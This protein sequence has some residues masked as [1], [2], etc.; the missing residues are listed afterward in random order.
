MAN[1]YAPE[2]EVSSNRI[3]AAG[4]SR[5]WRSCYDEFGDEI[6]PLSDWWSN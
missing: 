6:P 3:D 4:L 5:F 2:Q 1:A